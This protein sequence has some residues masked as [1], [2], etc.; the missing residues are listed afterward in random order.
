MI[1][2][3]DIYASHIYIFLE[4]PLQGHTTSQ[5]ERIQQSKECFLTGIGFFLACFHLSSCSDSTGYY[6]EK[7]LG[8]S[9]YMGSGLFLITET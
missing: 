4:K 2:S 5:N 3:L 8:T 9:S 1:F 6:I 7:V